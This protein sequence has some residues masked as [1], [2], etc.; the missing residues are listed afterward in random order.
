MYELSVISHFSA[1]HSIEGYPGEC[2]NIHG[3][4]Y[5]VKAVVECEKLD[6]IGLGIDFKILKTYLKEV[7]KT[8][9][10]TELNKISVFRERGIF[11]NPSAEN[12]ARYIFQELKERLKEPSV[13]LS[14]IV[15]TETEGA[16]VAYSPGNTV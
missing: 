6:K 16:S 11:A 5:T 13:R 3:H 7:L 9:D 8:L 10:H 1:A 4:N 12:I 14:K 2:A 15:I